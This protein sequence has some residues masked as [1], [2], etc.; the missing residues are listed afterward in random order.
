LSCYVQNTG[1]GA[2]AIYVQA[3]Y[4]VNQSLTDFAD[5]VILHVVISDFFAICRTFWDKIYGLKVTYF[6]IDRPKN[7]A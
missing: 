5:V 4:N 1:L 2:I 7:I 6:G 3:G